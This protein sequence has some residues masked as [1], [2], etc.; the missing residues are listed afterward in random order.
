MMHD[1]RRKVMSAIRDLRTALGLSQTEFGRRLNR[2][3]PTIQRWETLRPP[4]SKALAE[5]QQL[6]TESKQPELAKLFHAALVP[7][8]KTFELDVRPQSR[9]EAFH[10]GTLLAV[11]RL[12]ENGDSKSMMLMNKFNKLFAGPMDAYR[13]AIE[14]AEDQR[15]QSAWGPFFQAAEKAGLLKK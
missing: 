13:N 4:N 15:M 9:T 7:S 2:S 3:L 11:M 14:T 12:A 1:A 5:L 8:Y 6:A 10:L